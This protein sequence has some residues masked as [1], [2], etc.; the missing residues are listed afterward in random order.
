[1]TSDADVTGSE[2]LR[3]A[4]EGTVG[5]VLA[6]FLTPTF[7]ALLAWLGVGIVAKQDK[8]AAELQQQGQVLAR[9]ESAINVGIAEQLRSM[10]RRISVVEASNEK[11]R[12]EFYRHLA[13]ARGGEHNP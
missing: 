12:D 1:M 4:A 5:L 11:L 6:R 7:L 9:V 2:R 8:T 3:A 13:A 10:D